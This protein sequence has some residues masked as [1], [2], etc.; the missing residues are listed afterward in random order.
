VRDKE[1]GRLGEYTGQSF[2]VIGAV[3]AML[4]AMAGWDHFWIATASLVA[5]S[6]RRQ[7]LTTTRQYCEASARTRA[8]LGIPAPCATVATSRN[9]Y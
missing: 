4:M 7:S 3:A 5:S 8:A 6:P 9:I 1:I 2:V